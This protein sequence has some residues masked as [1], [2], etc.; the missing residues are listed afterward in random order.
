MNKINELYESLKINVLNNLNK[1]PFENWDLLSFD[2]PNLKI[3][4]SIFGRFIVKIH[5]SMV[6]DRIA[7]SYS[8]QSEPGKV[9]RHV[10]IVM[11][12]CF[13][14]NDDKIRRYIYDLEDYW[15]LNFN[16]NE[17]YFESLSV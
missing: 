14:K 9:V 2:D 5:T 10:E 6:S 15:N 7:I 3:W 12:T 17:C 8:L 16:L 1:I 4:K 11:S 13:N